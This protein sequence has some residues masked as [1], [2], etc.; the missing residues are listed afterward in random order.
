M[1]VE[2]KRVLFE[3]AKIYKKYVKNGRKDGKLLRIITCK[4]RDLIRYIEAY[5][6]YIGKEVFDPNIDPMKY[7]SVLNLLTNV[8]SPK[9]HICT[10]MILLIKRTYLIPFSSKQCTLIDTPSTLPPFNYATRHRFN[11]VDFV[12]GK[13]SSIIKSLT[14]INLMVGME[15]LCALLKS[16]VML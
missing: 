2:I 11:T 6:I 14:L 12:P 10:T 15:S 7:W 5:A 13:L 3:K 9:Y 16:A 8:K 1:T 4:C